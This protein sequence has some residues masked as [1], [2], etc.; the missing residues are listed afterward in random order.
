MPGERIFMGHGSKTLTRSGEYSI[1]MTLTIILSDRFSYSCSE[2][3]PAANLKGKS[4]TELMSWP[5]SLDRRLVPRDD[6]KT[7]VGTWCSGSEAWR[8]STAAGF[9]RTLL[10]EHIR[11][12][13]SLSPPEKFG[14]HGFEDKPDYFQLDSH[15][16]GHELL[17]FTYLRLGS[18]SIRNLSSGAVL[19]RCSG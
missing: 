19:T 4:L 12:R 3:V 17:D 13:S 9:E 7:V 8:W 16:D 11:S 18:T 5:L 15:L 10:V 1:V 2:T 14:M 6:P